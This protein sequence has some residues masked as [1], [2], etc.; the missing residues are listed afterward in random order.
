MQVV[1]AF[2]KTA[3]E[4]FLKDVSTR[5][6]HLQLAD[7]FARSTISSGFG[8]A[9]G[10][11]LRRWW[12]AAV[13]VL[14]PSTSVEPAMDGGASSLGSTDR[15]SARTDATSTLA[16]LQSIRGEDVNAQSNC[17]RALGNVPHRCCMTVRVDGL[18]VPHFPEVRTFSVRQFAGGPSC[19]RIS[20]WSAEVSS[21]SV[22][23]DMFAFCSA[24]QRSAGSELIPCSRARANACS[25]P[26]RHHESWPGRSQGGSEDNSVDPRR[27]TRAP[28]TA[29]VSGVP[30]GRVPNPVLAKRSPVQQ[31]VCRT[32]LVASKSGSLG[33]RE[34]LC[35]TMK[36]TPLVKNTQDDVICRMEVLMIMM[37]VLMPR[38]QSNEQNT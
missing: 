6:F 8:L 35:G 18:C 11:G 10:L 15:F 26:R 1:S 38:V 19:C 23:R 32:Q 22:V 27:D 36:S 24:T 37:V 17:H 2:C 31:V 7:H 25:L 12:L 4:S 3:P 33:G 14:L 9:F 5:H 16:G 30:P 28:S 21:S 13:V 34:M 29:N 20:R